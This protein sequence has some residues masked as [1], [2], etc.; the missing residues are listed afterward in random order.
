VK[1]RQIATGRL[2]APRGTGF[3][4]KH[5]RLITR[6][7]LNEALI[8]NS[9]VWDTLFP[10]EKRRIFRIILKEVDYEAST[11]K[12]GITLSERGLKLFN[13]ELGSKNG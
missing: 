2:I 9:P 7:E 10:K 12:L 4:Q 5:E 11:N 13:S 8:I 6:Q 3:E 1:C